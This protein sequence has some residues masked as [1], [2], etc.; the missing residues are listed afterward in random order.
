[1]IADI[2]T[3]AGALNATY[4][5]VNDLVYTANRAGGT[6]TVI[7]PTTLKKVANL[8][9]GTN[10]NHVETGGDGVVFA[11]N[12]APVVDGAATNAVFRIVPKAKPAKP[13]NSTRPAVSGTLAVGKTLKVSKGVWTNATGATYSY[14][15]LR[16]GASISGATK[17][18]YKGTSADAGK[19]L[20]AKVTV[21]VNGFTVSATSREVKI[22]KVTSK[23]TVSFNSATKKKSKKGTATVKVKASG[24]S[25]PTGT[26]TIYD[27]SKKIG[28]AKL[29]SAKKGVL[30]VTLKKLSKGTH[31]LKAT[32]SGNGQLKASTSSKTKLK[33]S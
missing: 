30:K 16:N 21:K 10:P 26:V 9:G 3:G 8:A 32:F 24:F 22:A 6:F 7:S 29:T 12:K 19:S 31:T 25:K 17:T 27:G 4:D 28:S 1:M 2:P 33:V 20:Q 11:V 18:S 5:P 23:T 14:R 13:V 15:W